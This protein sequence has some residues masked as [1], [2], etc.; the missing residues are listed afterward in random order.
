MGAASMG[1]NSSLAPS[2]GQ[3]GRRCHGAVVETR[4]DPHLR[5]F[6]HHVLGLAVI[7]NDGSRDAAEPLIV[8]PDDQGQQQNGKPALEK[9]LVIQSYC[10]GDDS[11]PGVVRDPAGRAAGQ[12]PAQVFPTPSAAAAQVPAG[13]RVELVAKHLTYSTASSFR[14]MPGLAQP[15]PRALGQP[16]TLRQRQ[17]LG[18]P[19]PRAEAS[20]RCLLLAKPRCPLRRGHRSHRGRPG[21]RRPDGASVRRAVWSLVPVGGPTRSSNRRD[22]GDEPRRADPGLL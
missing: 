8:T 21:R 20:G 22:R 3:R 11:R 13:Y 9:K 14:S 2:C 4:A 17:R 18:R 7:A 1:R 10:F 6:L 15:V 19:A 16:R 5:N 12:L